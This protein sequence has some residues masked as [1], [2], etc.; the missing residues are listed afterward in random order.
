MRFNP[1][2]IKTGGVTP[3]P[4]DWQRPADWI[5]IPSISTGEEVVLSNLT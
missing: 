3:T 4:S 1:I 2:I 5:P